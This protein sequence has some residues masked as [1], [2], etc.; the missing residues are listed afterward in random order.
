MEVKEDKNSKE[1]IGRLKPLK[2]SISVKD[3]E[4]EDD[5]IEISLL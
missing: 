2:I 5:S 4:Y 1:S 3:E